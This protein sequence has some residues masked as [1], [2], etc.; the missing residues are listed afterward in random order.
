MYRNLS[1][2]LCLPCRNEG[3]HLVKVIEKVPSIVDEIIVISNKSTDNTVEVAK[4]LG[5]KVIEENRALNGI[6]YGYGRYQKCEI[7]HYCRRRR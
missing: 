6:G 7:R 2:T 4:S 5:V 1:I 3:N